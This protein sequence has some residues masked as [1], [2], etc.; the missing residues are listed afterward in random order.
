MICGRIICSAIVIISISFLIYFNT[1]A[2]SFHLDDYRY[3]INNW[4]FKDYINQPFS[5]SQTLSSLSNRSIV[6]A[7]LHFN[8]S[9][10]GFNVLGFHIVNLMIHILTSLFVFLFVKEILQINMFIKA[11]DEFKIKIN[12]PLIA[13]LLFAVHPINTQAVTYITGRSSLLVTCFYL[14]AFIF[15]IK[16]IKQNLQLD[17]F[18]TKPSF[19]A[20]SLRK[21]LFFSI[22]A[23]FLVAGF[24]SKMTIITAPLLL[25]IF[26]LFSIVQHSSSKHTAL[27]LYFN[28]RFVK[29]FVQ[30]AVVSS[31]LI[32]ILISYYLNFQN[33]LVEGNG[34][35]SK[36]LPT[37]YSKLFHLA[38]FT[39]D[40]INSSIY[41]L[42]EF[43]VIVFYYIKNILFP[44]NQNID[45]DFPVAQG[46]TDTGV[47]LSLGIIAICLYF[48]IYY[49]KKNRIISF[50]LFWFFI[51]L[52]PTSSILP[53]LDTV[54]EHRLYLPL[55]GTV[56]SVSV[57]LNLFF[58]DQGNNSFK[59]LIYL[60][61]FIFLP[62]IILTTLTIKRNFVWKD[63]ISLWSDAAK[64]SPRV[65][66]PL[67]NLGESY[68]KVKDYEKAI[69]VLKKAISISPDFHKSFNNLGKIYGKLG[70]F[71]LAIENLKQALVKKPKYPLGHYNLAKV[72]DLKGMLDFAIS[73]YSIAFEQKK[74]F[75]EACYN[76]ANVF[77]K[78]GKY[79]KAIDT[80]LNCQKLKPSYPK[81]Y[82]AIGLIL[83]K[84][85][86]IDEAFKYYSRAVELDDKF[87]LAR[88][89]MGKIYL[90]KGNSNEAIKIFKQ[91]I[92][93]DPNNFQAHYSLGLVFL[94]QLNNP[95][96]AVYHLKKSLAINPE[97]PNAKVLRML[98][99]QIS[100]SVE[101]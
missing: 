94:Q 60:I 9:L 46:L 1:F 55:A 36:H 10:D 37:I 15:F 88:I 35:L 85:G 100:D 101:K 11:Q 50:G 81:T 67:N 22:S 96:M 91:V 80:Y 97:H 33:F 44:I 76:L 75:F 90:M 32:L 71:D 69:H 79:K 3:I 38:S 93:Q 95:S 62:I 20:V 34:L 84:T 98:I 63:E 70:Q 64:K 42:T 45:P 21:L 72:Y 56:I 29:I 53:L 52:L 57:F 27:K 86:N 13:A 19:M 78:K 30:V 18:K 47:V 17:Y 5:V 87:Y 68:D 92:K 51:T 39:K 73:E 14:G 7:T 4:V 12:I 59:Q 58:S 26:Y 82:F 31:P 48:G 49:Y 41:L 8:Y 24:G 99:S 25:I 77:N 66:R 74:D 61:I 43:K 2:G 28:N 23:G 40:V 65:S 89:A 54:S 83:T 6:L 16:G